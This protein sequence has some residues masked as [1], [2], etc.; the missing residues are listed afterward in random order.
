MYK[1]KLW[2][3]SSP[4]RVEYSFERELSGQDKLAACLEYLEYLLEADSFWKRV[5]AKELMK[6]LRFREMDRLEGDGTLHVMFGY[7]MTITFKIE[8]IGTPRPLNAFL[9]SSHAK[10]REMLKG[11]DSNEILS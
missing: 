10:I 9:T 1:I 11:I 4:K 3:S 2:N 6:D 5:R 8:K 7:A